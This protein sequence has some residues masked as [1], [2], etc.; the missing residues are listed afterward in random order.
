MESVPPSSMGSISMASDPWI[1]MENLPLVPLSL[2]D[3]HAMV[4][5]TFFQ[6]VRILPMVKSL[7]CF[8]FNLFVFFFKVNPTIFNGTTT[9]HHP[10]ETFG[11]PREV[12]INSTMKVCKGQ[13]MRCCDF[14]KRLAK[15]LGRRSCLLASGGEDV[16]WWGNVCGVIEHGNLY[17]T[18]YYIHIIYIIYIYIYIHN[19]YI[20]IYLN[21]QIKKKYIFVILL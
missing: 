1:F 15:R 8:S 7:E 12:A 5:G 21:Q 9:S 18:G 10:V 17:S 16:Q 11:K 6:D 3:L 2:G 4:E 19:I 14:A 13:W 20:Y